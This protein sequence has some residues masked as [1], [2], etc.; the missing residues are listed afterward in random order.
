M[1]RLKAVGEGCVSDD[2]VKISVLG[3]GARLYFYLS[4]EWGHGGRECS[5]LQATFVNYDRS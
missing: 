2:E 5:Q 3:F 1:G 4:G